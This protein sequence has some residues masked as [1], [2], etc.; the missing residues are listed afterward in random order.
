MHE[1]KRRAGDAAGKPRG[2]QALLGA[3][4]AMVGALATVHPANALLVALSEAVPKLAA[5]LP[6]VITAC[7]A[8]LAAMSDPPDMGRR[9]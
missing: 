9:K 4:I 7:G 1:P 3:A 5:T 6:P 2:V 8:L